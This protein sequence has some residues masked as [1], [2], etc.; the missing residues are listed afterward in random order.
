MSDASLPYQI[1]D[2]A[3]AR[4]AVLPLPADFPGTAGDDTLES[5]GSVI[6]E[7]DP[8]ATRAL[9]QDVPKAYHT[10]STTSC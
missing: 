6:A 2:L 7:L 10:R 4:A 8:E 5:A 3:P 1:G 9:L